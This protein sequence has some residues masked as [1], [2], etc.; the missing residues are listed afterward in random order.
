MKGA[1]YI[2]HD[3]YTEVFCKSVTADNYMSCSEVT[4]AALSIYIR[5]SN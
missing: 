2:N 1:G 4:Y 3:I 5:I